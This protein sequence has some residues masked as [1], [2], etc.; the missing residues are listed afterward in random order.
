MAIQGT[1]QQGS[2]LPEE[3]AQKLGIGIETAGRTTEWATQLAVRDFHDS[4][5]EG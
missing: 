5:R 1:R 3:L 2:K 4:E